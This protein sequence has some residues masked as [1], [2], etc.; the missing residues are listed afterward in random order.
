[1]MNNYRYL[2]HI[3]IWNIFFAIVLVP[4]AGKLIDVFGIP[5]SITIYYFPF[6]YVFSDVMTEVYG[7]AV[8]RRMLWYIIGAQVLSTL[9]F[10][11]VVYYPPSVVMKDNQS[12][13]DVFSVAP[14]M[15]CFGVMALFLGDISNNYVLAKLKVWTKGKYVPF[16]FVASTISG[17][18]VDTGF[19]YVFGLW[20]LLPTSA[21]LKSVLLASSIKIAIEILFLPL[22]LRLT[23]L[24]KKAE[25]VD[26]F[27][28]KTDFNPLKL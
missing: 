9:V 6:I 1:M 11:F 2:N 22:T 23:A 26:F 7:Y 15:V 24:I 5:L 17:Q 13:V 16:R 25:N 20:G 12:Y 8:A 21:M 19:F 10:Q 4:T 28:D 27:D 3:T 18:V 14:R